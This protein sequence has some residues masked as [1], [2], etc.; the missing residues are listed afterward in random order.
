[1]LMRSSEP[2]ETSAMFI[3]ASN[4]VPHGGVAVAVDQDSRIYGPGG[5]K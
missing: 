5:W 4:T 2:S 3:A 1:M